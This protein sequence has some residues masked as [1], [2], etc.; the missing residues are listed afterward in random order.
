MDMIAQEAGTVAVVHFQGRVV[1]VL[2]DVAHM[3]LVQLIGMDLL[4]LEHNPQEGLGRD[5]LAV[6][7]VGG[8][9]SLLAV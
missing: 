8:V 5:C 1:L 9:E 3:G 4:G 7:K 6:D 2:T